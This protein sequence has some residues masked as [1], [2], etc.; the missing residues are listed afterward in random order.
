MYTSRPVTSRPAIPVRLTAEEVE[1]FDRLAEAVSARVGGMKVSRSELMRM[2][3]ARGLPLVE[4]E[5]G[6]KAP[7]ARKGKG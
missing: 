3:F 2:L 6:I 1:R 5:Y 4:A 7:R